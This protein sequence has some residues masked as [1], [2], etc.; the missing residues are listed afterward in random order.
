[1]NIKESRFTEEKRRDDMETRRCQDLFNQQ[2]EVSAQ[3]NSYEKAARR[4]ELEKR[5][6]MR[7]VAEENMM[8]A[9]NKRRSQ[10][11]DHVTENNR[12]ADHINSNKVT[13]STMIR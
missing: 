1:M 4:A 12:N 7:R 13:Y 5:E 3:K 6:Q 11:Q 10:L 8:L 9:N 2:A